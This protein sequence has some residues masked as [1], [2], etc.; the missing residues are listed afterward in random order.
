M[1]SYEIAE[2]APEPVGGAKAIYTWFNE[3]IDLQKFT[4]S[5]DS[6][7]GRIIVTFIINEEGR[8]VQPEIARGIGN[9]YD[10]Y[11][12]DL[13]SRIPDEWTPGTYGRKPIKVRMAYPFRFC[14]HH[15]TKPGRKRKEEKDRGTAFH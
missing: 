13:V 4:I 2:T 6:F 12:L 8:L 3:N 7:N 5:C 10:E 15:P 1:L 9:P 14:S 11:C